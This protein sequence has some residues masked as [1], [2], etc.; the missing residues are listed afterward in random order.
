M[1][2]RE[3]MLFS[4]LN[5]ADRPLVIQ[6]SGTDP[7]IMAEAA[8]CVAIMCSSPTCDWP[9]SSAFV[10]ANSSLL[11]SRYIHRSIYV[12]TDIDKN[13]ANYLGWSH[14]TVTLWM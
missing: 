4:Q 8:R 10:L 6:F 2:R 9:R 3:D 14:N 11:I 7:V 13:H 1:G 12:D 5:S